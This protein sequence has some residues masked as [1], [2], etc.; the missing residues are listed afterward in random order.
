ME[1]ADQL[2]FS[3]DKNNYMKVL[4]KLKLEEI[5]EKDLN[6]YYKGCLTFHQSILEF[7]LIIPIA[8]PQ[9]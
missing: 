8:Y 3:I 7:I 1:Y 9:R 6:S 4:D 2:K 5:D